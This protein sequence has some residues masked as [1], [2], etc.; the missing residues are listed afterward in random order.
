MSHR[1]YVYRT[2]YALGIASSLI[3][4]AQQMDRPQPAAVSGPPVMVVQAAAGRI[5]T[6]P[7][8]MAVYTFDKD[9]LGT[10]N[11]YDACALY[12][13]PVLARGGEQP[14]GNLSVKARKDGTI[15][16]AQRGMPLYTFAQD[17]RPGDMKGDNY[18]STW[19]VAR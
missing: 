18:E 15:Q 4:C 2:F 1:R 17:K 12:W 6:T 16:W 5:L 10:S 13:S 8:G 19:H 9:T 11:C 7:S 3:A 14:T